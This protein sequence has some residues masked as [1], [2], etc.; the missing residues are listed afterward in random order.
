MVR[1]KST[2]SKSTGG[3]PF[4]NVKKVPQEEIRQVSFMDEA[5]V[6]IK[7]VNTFRRR[8]RVMIKS[9]ELFYPPTL[10][11]KAWYGPF[12]T[13]CICEN[14][15]IE[16]KDHTMWMANVPIKE[17]MHMQDYMADLSSWRE[18]PATQWSEF[19]T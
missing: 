13:N 12:E 1:T 19:N 10:M 11:H 7:D 16:V 9:H 14:N 8:D 15:R 3:R 2:S 6:K 4:G 17:V 5:L 18:K